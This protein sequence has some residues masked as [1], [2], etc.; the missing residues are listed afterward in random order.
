MAGKER[1]QSIRNQFG[2]GQEVAMK[3]G[4]FRH[5]EDGNARPR[6]LIAGNE[7]RSEER[8]RGGGRSKVRR[9]KDKDAFMHFRDVRLIDCSKNIRSAA[10]EGKQ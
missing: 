3:P 10:E 2:F 6:T 7:R 5:E 4:G 9:K 1:L 8:E